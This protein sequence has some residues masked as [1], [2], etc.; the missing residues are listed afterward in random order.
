MEKPTKPGSVG[1]SEGC[2]DSGLDAGRIQLTTSLPDPD[3]TVKD[4]RSAQF[5]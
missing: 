4:L 1:A 3:K 5:P 2:A